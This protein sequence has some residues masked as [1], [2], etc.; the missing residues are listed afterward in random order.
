MS[1]EKG[2][3]RGLSLGMCI[4]LSM[5]AIIGA[6]VFSF[7][8]YGIMY[9]GTGVT[10]AF[11]LAGLL[12]I[13]MTLPSMQLG[14]AIPATGG[15]YMYVSRF[16]HPIFG[17]VQI[18]NSLIGVLNI[19]VMSI[20]FSEY[21]ASIVPNTPKKLVGVAIALLLAV[22]A[23]FG[24]KISGWVQNIIVTIMLC[25]IGLYFI[26]GFGHINPDYMSL[27]KAFQPLGGLA[28]LW[29]AIAILRYTTQGGTIVMALGDEVKNP[30]FTIPFAFLAGT[31]IVTV[32]YAL[33]SIVAVGVLPMDQVAGKSLA[34]SAAV[35]LKGGWFSAFIIGGGLLATLTTLNGSFLI[36]SRLHYA[37][38]RDGIW[39]KVFTKTNKYGVPWVTLWGATFV[40]IIPVIL[41]LSLGDVLK[42]VAVPGMMLAIIY[43]IP[44]LLL[45]KKLP[46]CHKKA[47]F[48]MPQWLTS[49]ICV[50]SVIISTSLGMSLFKRMKPAH[51]IGMIIFFGIGLIYW[52]VRVNYLKNNENINLI[53]KMKGFHPY[54]EEK[55]KELS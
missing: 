30:G 12:T 42:I 32:L 8:G 18:L 5:G 22:S 3:K 53:E 24:V 44:P 28:G 4:T 33:V 35:F 50:T 38:A 16:V 37:A 41:G 6:G 51:Y 21:F 52:F 40:G 49:F 27:A 29:A 54:W 36:Y 20:S 39:P 26:P 48:S 9:S 14:S 45:P 2:L 31:G 13:Y 11:V 1:N 10:L 55:E 23:T 34:A 47:W 15:T 25:A 19:A 7:T 17:Y 46:N 43:Y